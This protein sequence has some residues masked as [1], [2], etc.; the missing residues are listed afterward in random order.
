MKFIREILFERM[1]LCYVNVAADPE[2]V[3]HSTQPFVV[4]L[5]FFFSFQKVSS[6]S[7]LF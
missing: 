6:V 5:Y 7:S 2:N 3:V 1:G 4:D